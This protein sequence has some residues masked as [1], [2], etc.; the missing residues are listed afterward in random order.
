MKELLQIRDA[1][2][3]LPAR[4]VS[5]LGDAMTLI[6]L[7]VLIART[8]RPLDLTVLLV[9]F[10][11]PVVALASVAGRLVDSHDSRLLLTAAGLVQVLGSAGLLVST[12]LP[13]QVGCVLLVQSG[14]AVSGPAWGALLPRIVGEER[15]G[16]AIGAQQAL[17]SGAWLAGTALGGLAYAA[18]GFRGVVLVDTLTFAALVLAARAVHTRRAPDATAGRPIDPTSRPAAEPTAGRRP[19][20]GLESGWQVLRRD[21]VSTLLVIA[22]VVFVMALEGTNV[23]ESFLVIDVLGAGPAAYG[24][25]GLALGVGV[26]LGSVLCGRVG[27]DRRRVAVLAAAALG[28]GLTIGG[29][30]LVPGV[31]WLFPLFFAAGVGN[32]FLNGLG[33]ALVVGRTPDAGRGRVLATVMGLTRAGSVVSLLVAGL[34][35]GLVGPRPVFVVGGLLAAATAGLVLRARG[36]VPTTGDE[37][38]RSASG[39]SAPRADAPGS[40]QRSAPAGAGSGGERGMPG[41]ASALGA[42]QLPVVGVLPRTVGQQVGGVLDPEPDEAEPLEDRV[43]G[44]VVR[45]GHGRQ[46]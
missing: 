6:G 28:M 35:G 44:H 39:P 24:L 33:F 32:G 23:M 37:P 40:W 5:Q 18:V 46:A 12:A 3:A 9:A 14:Q 25:V 31:G 4:A 7:S 10:A 30:G 36:V 34:A 2:I 41:A 45:R 16:R 1:R 8:G 26:T 27:T 43:G 20:E 29:A 15:L 13:W 17:G 21:R 42:E 19:A 11:L 38:R 22:L